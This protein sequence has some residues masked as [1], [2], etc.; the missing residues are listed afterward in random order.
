MISC[1]TWYGSHVRYNDVYQEKNTYIVSDDTLL[2]KI[3][4]KDDFIEP[5]DLIAVFVFHLRAVARVYI[6]IN[7]VSINT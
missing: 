1:M 4:G 5:V 2:T 3:D 7:L 6:I